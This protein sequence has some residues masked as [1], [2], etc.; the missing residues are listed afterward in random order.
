MK[1]LNT[2]QM[3][4]E[5]ERRPIRDE[6]REEQSKRSYCENMGGA[7]GF[8]ICFPNMMQRLKLVPKNLL[9]NLLFRNSN[10]G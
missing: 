6:A 9:N 2:G 3:A 7:L 10:F 8:L 5:R 1:L 4:A